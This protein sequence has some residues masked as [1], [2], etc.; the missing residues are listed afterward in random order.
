[1]PFLRSK[2]PDSRNASNPAPAPSQLG[3]IAALVDASSSLSLISWVSSPA[4]RS[5]TPGP[6]PQIVAP[7]PDLEMVVPAVDRGIT[8]PSPEPDVSVPT[9]G[10]DTAA[11][12][13]HAEIAVRA[14]DPE[15]D[16]PTAPEAPPSVAGLARPVTPST[17]PDTAKSVLHGFLATAKDGSALF[18]PLKAALVG[19]V[20]L[21]DVWDVSI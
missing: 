2:R 8:V 16:P 11:P 19:V 14:P 6:Y 1:M 4:S 3:A 20:A 15:S 10:P 9:P 17:G 13:A 21:W 18:L 7:T 5:V 12:A